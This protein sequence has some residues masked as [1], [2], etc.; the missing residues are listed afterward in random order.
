VKPRH[1]R[2]AAEGI[3]LRGFEDFLPT[4]RA[5]HR[6]SDRFKVLELPLF[7]GYVFGSFSLQDK[8]TILGT[9]GIRSIVSSANIP[10]P[11]PDTEIE[12]I[13]AAVRSGLPVRPSPAAGIGK[14]VSV[15]G[16]PLA[17][18]EGILTRDKGSYR[19]VIQVE[20][21]NRSVA[22]EIDRE[23]LGSLREWVRCEGPDPA[24]KNRYENL[25]LRSADLRF[26]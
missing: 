25:D 9:P 2:T 19:V 11:V 22:V 12:A 18:L 23:M 20:L 17:G 16:G 4:Y 5:R 10:C 21:L 24:G 13:K 8:L 7:P 26:V 1:E 15:Q 6:W 14:T 3:R